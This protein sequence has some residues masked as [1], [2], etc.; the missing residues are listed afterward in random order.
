MAR[1]LLPALVV[2]SCLIHVWSMFDPWF[3]E[4]S[5][6]L[7]R[8]FQ[9]EISGPC[10]ARVSTPTF[11]ASWAICKSIGPRN[12]PRNSMKGDRSPQTLARNLS[13][14]NE[15][16]CRFDFR[17]VRRVELLFFSAYHLSI[18]FYVVEICHFP[19]SLRS[20][21]PGVGWTSGLPPPRTSATTA[22]QPMPWFFRSGRSE[23]SNTPELELV[24]VENSHH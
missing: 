1:W 8:G 16:R 6:K 18:S 12:C 10:F 21:Q 14:K 7:W 3:I 13:K 19:R 11:S 2:W 22:V 23:L 5:G 17:R 15:P 4:F 24:A 20:H 9:H